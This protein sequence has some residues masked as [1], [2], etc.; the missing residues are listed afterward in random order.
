MTSLRLTVAALLAV[1]GGAG[2]AWLGAGALNPLAPA[3]FSAARSSGAG[4]SAAAQPSPWEPMRAEA[5]YQRRALNLVKRAAATDDEVRRHQLLTR[6]SGWQRR[7]LASRNP[8]EPA[9]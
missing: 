3:V 5:I 8:P 9:T 7:A 4:H 1:A 6:A 2:Q